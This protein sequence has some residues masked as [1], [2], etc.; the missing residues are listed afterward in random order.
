[1]ATAEE[2]IKSSLQL[3]LVQASEAPLQPDEY[4]SGIEYINDIAF[5]WDGQGISLGFTTISSLGDE[6]TIPSY[7][8]QAL[9]HELAMRLAPQFGGN[10]GPLLVQNSQ[11]SFRAMMVA[12]TIVEPSQYPCTLPI[13]S[14]NYDER[15]GT[16]DHFFPCAEDEMLTEVE[17]SILLEDGD[18]N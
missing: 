13:G 18:N 3:L 14:G 16:R 6:V 8:N 9:K 5:E 7:A 2:F 11:K 4:Q 17:G 10:V 1:M 15:F 12:N